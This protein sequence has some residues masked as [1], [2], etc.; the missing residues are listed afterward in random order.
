MGLDSRNA[1]C[2][3][4][5]CDAP[6]RA[7]I[8]LCCDRAILRG[9]VSRDV[10]VR[11]RGCSIVKHARLAIRQLELLHLRI[12]RVNN[13]VA[14]DVAEFL[15]QHRLA[16]GQPAH[17]QGNDPGVKVAHGGGRDGKGHGS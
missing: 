13:P 8:Q 4:V 14:V 15:D 12:P 10:E 5:N 1:Y 9:Q 2:A 17:L 11:Y 6:L 16:A 7:R 3:T